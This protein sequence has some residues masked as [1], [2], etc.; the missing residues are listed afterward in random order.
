MRSAT[1]LL[2][3]SFGASFRWI[4]AISAGGS[5]GVLVFSRFFCVSHRFAFVSAYAV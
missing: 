1:P 2:K 4:A 5:P 3:E